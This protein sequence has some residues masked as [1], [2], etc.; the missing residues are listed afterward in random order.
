MPNPK[1]FVL[2]LDFDGCTDRP[3]SHRAIVTHVLDVYR[4]NQSIQKIVL[5]IGSLR[6]SLHLDILNALRNSTFPY[7]SCTSLQ[8]QLMPLLKSQLDTEFPEQEIEIVFDT[9]LQS[10]VYNELDNG[11]C[12]QTMKKVFHTTSF[13]SSRAI[14]QSDF[15]EI[16]MDKHG[17]EIELVHAKHLS[18]CS[19]I[20]ILYGQFHHIATTYA[21]T[22]CLM[23]FYDDRYDILRS[24]SQFYN[25]YPQWIPSCISLQLFCHTSLPDH[26]PINFGKVITGIGETNTDFKNHLLKLAHLLRWNSIPENFPEMPLYFEEA[27]TTEIETAVFHSTEEHENQE[28]NDYTEIP[29]PTTFIGEEPL[30]GAFQAIMKQANAILKA[31]SQ[32]ELDFFN[33]YLETLEYFEEEQPLY[34]ATYLKQFYFEKPRLER[35]DFLKLSE[36]EAVLY[37]Y[38]PHNYEKEIEEAKDYAANRCLLD[39]RIQA[40]QAEFK[41]FKF[42]TAAKLALLCEISTEEFLRKVEIF[43]NSKASTIATPKAMR[44][45]ASP[46]FFSREETITGNGDKPSLGL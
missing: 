43:K 10:D 3:S 2:S 24:L 35:E 13:E 12:F 17:K 39:G 45:S 20:S 22:P 23:H 15:T 38:T 32:D 37:N 33:E 18:D 14:E 1:C 7:V 26:M 21:Q 41:S 19:K 40:H 44:P 29:I 25:R 30:I 42:N 16:V 6:Q 9:F 8:E 46:S 11:T 28:E 36:A 4:Q 34:E 5:I 31:H 27:L